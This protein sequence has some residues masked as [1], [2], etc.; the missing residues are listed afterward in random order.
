MTF[1]KSWI[2]IWTYMK[3]NVIEDIKLLVVCLC[4]INIFI[5]I[6]LS[7]SHLHWH[8]MKEDISARGCWLLTVFFFLHQV[9]FDTPA[10]WRH[11][12]NGC[13]ARASKI[14]EGHWRKIWILQS[15]SCFWLAS[16]WIKQSSCCHLNDSLIEI[17]PS[18]IGTKEC[19][20]SVL[21]W[22]RREGKIA[23]MN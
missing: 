21:I 23:T 9:C 13:S 19:L 18:F 6:S 14:L 10:L 2:Y 8:V 3:S 22:R 1:F 15:G 5:S 12:L 11:R 7:F 4:F 16:D 20:H 17:W